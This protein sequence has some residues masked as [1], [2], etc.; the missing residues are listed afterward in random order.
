MVTERR[1]RK[2]SKIGEFFP[3]EGFVSLELKE[4]GSPGLRHSIDLVDLYMRGDF[5]VN[6]SVQLCVRVTLRRKQ[7]K[8]KHTLNNLKRCSALMVR[9]RKKCY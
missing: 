4:V 5:Y 6:Q 7:P 2:G 1:R 8:F 3:T 9:D